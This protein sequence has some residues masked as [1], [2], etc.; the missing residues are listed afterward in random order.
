M[1]VQEGLLKKTGKIS[2]SDICVN[3]VIFAILVLCTANLYSAEI[4]TNL[5][6]SEIYEDEF[7]LIEIALEGASR[8]SIQEIPEN[9][10]LSIEFAGQSRSF[11][12]GTG[13][14]RSATILNFR[15]TPR[16][17]GSFTI[18]PIKIKADGVNVQ[19]RSMAL[20]VLEGSDPTGRSTRRGHD[21]FDLFFGDIT[22]E[23]AKKAVFLAEKSVSRDIVYTGETIL[24]RYYI[25]AEPRINLQVEA[26]NNNKWDGFIIKPIEERIPPTPYSFNGKTM[27]RHH[28]ITYQLIPT[29]SGNYDFTGDV[30]SFVYQ[31]PS[32][33]FAMRMR[34][35][36]PT[37]AI[38]VDVLPLPADN[39]PGNFTGNIGNFDIAFQNSEALQTETGKEV[40]LELKISG[41]GE[42]SQLSAPQFENIPGVTILFSGTEKNFSLVNGRESGSV[43]YR[44][45][46]IADNPGE[47]RLA[48]IEFSL[49]DPD[50]GEYK[51]INPDPL[52]LSV[53]EAAVDFNYDY[54]VEEA[55]NENNILLYLSVLL[56]LLT[57]VGVACFLVYR[58]LT[59]NRKF[60]ESHET[61]KGEAL[62]C[63]GELP[64]MAEL[65]ILFKMRLDEAFT[66]GEAASCFKELLNVVN[67]LLR[68]K[69][70]TGQSRTQ[71]EGMQ[72]YLV[73]TRYGGGSLSLEI[74]TDI[75]QKID[76]ILV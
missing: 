74:L 56:I 2:F 10:D 34:N 44:Y 57:V 13:G 18:S 31:D 70:L 76:K 25:V 16:R 52:L 67:Y 69:R 75:K 66:T 62:N 12:F 1:D 61:K 47:Y 42:L 17:S 46:V 29:N 64:P 50:R 59:R 11:S 41:V 60:Q 5:H 58:E 71:L 14:S 6:R 72:K 51:T 4:E 37:N 68:E 21:P 20:T 15:V 9:G 73:S 8:V 55:E 22:E 53:T 19:S 7:T 26:I 3:C 40:S 36:L 24:L 35:I 30:I 27:T 39:K 32:S 43:L 28:V 54:S 33:R 38:D 23:P 63:I 48:L 65:D 49:F 45:T